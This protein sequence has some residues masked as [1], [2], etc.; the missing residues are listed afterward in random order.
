VIGAPGLI[1]YTLHSDL[2]RV[3]QAIIREI[4]RYLP[5]LAN[6]DRSN[7]VSPQA[8]SSHAMLFPELNEL[9]IDELQEVLENTDLQV[10]KAIAKSEDIAVYDT[11]SSNALGTH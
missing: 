11:Y 5:N 4:Q 2:G 1:N 7:D 10:F 9:T 3:V 6:E 8:V